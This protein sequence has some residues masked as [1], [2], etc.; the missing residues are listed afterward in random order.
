MLAAEFGHTETVQA[1]LT[2]NDIN[3]IHQDNKGKMAL[4]FAIANGHTETIL[5]LLSFT[6]ISTGTF[7]GY[8]RS[9]LMRDNRDLTL[10]SKVIKKLR[11][12]RDL[13]LTSTNIC[14]LAQI[15]NPEQVNLIRNERM[16]QIDLE[17][18]LRGYGSIK[19]EFSLPE[20]AMDLIAKFSIL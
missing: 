2:A 18:T 17:R 8:L 12:L 6:T 16:K 4:I 14:L 13:K 9:L 1:L 11:L 7:F 5:A 15:T 10:L 19:N 20:N 3:V